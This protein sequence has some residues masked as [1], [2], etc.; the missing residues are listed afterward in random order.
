MH[1]PA[2]ADQ[3]FVLSIMSRDRVGIV[4]DVAGAIR[5]LHGDI[6]DLS[7]T[8]LRG[9]FTMILLVTFPDEVDEAQ[10]VK[11]LSKLNSGSASPLEISVLRAADAAAAPLAAPRDSYVITAR[12]A[13][14]IG[15]VA[16]VADFC[17]E[18]ALNIIDL[19][20]MVDGDDYVMILQIELGE[21]EVDDVRH[22][23]VAFRRETGMDV[24]L[25]HND[26]V[27]AMNEIALV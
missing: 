21:I 20:T 27:Q 8:V 15:F 10:I 23:L 7:Q 12:G 6:A 26:I 9:Y 19:A 14:R 17:A 22:R 4:R 5:D 2:M 25:Q 1:A 13:D 11:A 18:N 24:V 3:P 16:T